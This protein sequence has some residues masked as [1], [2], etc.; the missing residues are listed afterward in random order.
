MDP[1]CAGARPPPKGLTAVNILRRLPLPRLLALC[2]S[3]LVIGISITA[4][5]LAASA[6]PTP[7]AR[8][9][10]QAVHDALAGSAPQGFSATIT[11]TDKLLEGANLA[12]AGAGGPEGGGSGEL[13]SN[14]LLAGGSGRLWVSDGKL[15]LELQSEQGDTQV[16]YDGTTAEL[17]DAATNTLYRYTPPAAQGQAQTGKGWTS[18]APLKDQAPE[19]PSVGKIEEAIARLGEHAVVSG[20]T[21]TDVGG[22]A[23]YTVRVS[24]KEGGSLLGG[25]ELSFDAGN[26]TPLRAA[27]YSSQSSSPV[28]ELAAGEVSYG[29]VSPSVFDF[30]PPSSARVIELKSPE[31]AAHPEHRDGRSAGKPDLTSHG[32]GLST[33]WVLEEKGTV[34]SS[35]S[36][37]GLPK[38]KIAGVSA[39][40]LRTELGTVLSFER[41]GVSYVLAGAVAPKEVEALASGL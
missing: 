41:S 12:G 22:Q 36:L 27:I 39:S 24:P 35:K 18:Y 23:A 28:I 31:G 4:I 11:L 16:I 8:P 30:T 40:E 5:A 1:F 10:A 25:I 17:Y 2:G 19:V 7:P 6:G 34:G 37:T 14:P 29:S 32:R 9:L 13:T 20:A 21:P 38:V 3:V 15:R 33:I 26:G